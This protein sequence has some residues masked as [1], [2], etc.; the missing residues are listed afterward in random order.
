MQQTGVELCQAQVRW[1]VQFVTFGQLRNTQSI[2]NL[3][4][5]ENQDKPKNGVTSTLKAT[6]QMGTT[7]KCKTTSE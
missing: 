4:E 7:L 3:Q 5:N 2:H 1:S 6:L